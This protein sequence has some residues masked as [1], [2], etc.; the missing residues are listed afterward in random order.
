MKKTLSFLFV[1]AMLASTPAMAQ[2]YTIKGTAPKDATFAYLKNWKVSAM[3]RPTA[4][5]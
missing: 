3:Q 5:P 2:T 1:A 4:W